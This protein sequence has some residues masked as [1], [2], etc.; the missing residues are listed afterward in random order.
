[1]TSNTT[2]SLEPLL[3]ALQSSSLAEAVPSSRRSDEVPLSLRLQRLWQERGDFSAL[4]VEA[5]C[6]E[7]ARDDEAG[8]SE[9][10]ED[11][12]KQEDEGKTTA[13]AAQDGEDSQA[14]SPDELWE[15]KVNI[16]S[17]LECVACPKSLL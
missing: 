2:I 5:L 13:D 10:A 11:A 6:E 15:L 8:H 14:M 7:Q 3:Q 12:V 4:G 17:G 9:L 16:L 1:M